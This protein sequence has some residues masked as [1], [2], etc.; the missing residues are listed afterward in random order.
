MKK[1]LASIFIFLSITL[2]NAQEELY[3]VSV[4]SSSLRSGPGTNYNVV[5]ELGKGMQVLLIS[6]DFGDW[7]TV[8]YKTM[9]GFIRRSDIL[10]VPAGIVIQPNE[11]DENDGDYYEEEDK[12]SNKYDD[13]ESTEY[14]TG[15]T[16]ECL[17]IVPE[18]DYSLDNYLK[19]NNVGSNTEAVVKL[20]KIDNTNGEE[21]TYRIAYIQDGDVHQMKNIPAGKYYLKIAYG[22]DWREF[23][24]NGNCFGRF[25]ENPQYEKGDD[26][27]DF[28]P[29]K[30]SKGTDVPSYE[31][32]LDVSNSSSNSLETEDI[33][34]KDFNN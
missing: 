14:E 12:S 25:V 7:W 11:E 17:N 6:E 4:E 30:T 18:F 31:L 24:E 2:V 21:L 15:E 5:A 20:I 27:V 16:P 19:I 26:I 1:F 29:V 10:A 9:N 22:K 23:T 34:E 13:W 32:S 3:F 8:Q 33:S 28:T